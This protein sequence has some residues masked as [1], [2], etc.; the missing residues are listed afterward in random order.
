[1]RSRP[2]LKI[3]SDKTRPIRSPNFEDDSIKEIMDMERIASSSL[4]RLTD[5]PPDGI[6]GE[7][8][9]ILAE[10]VDSFRIDR[11]G[12][13]KL[14][15]NKGEVQV[16]NL[17]Q[18]QD[19]PKPMGPMV[20]QGIF[21]WSVERLINGDIVCFSD[22]DDL[23]PE[24]SRDRLDFRGAG[25]DSCLAIPLYSGGSVEFCIFA[26]NLKSGRIW[27]KEAI[28]L[29]RLIGEVL[30]NTIVH[31]RE[32]GLT[33]ARLRFDRFISDLSVRFINVAPAGLDLEIGEA[34]QQI[35]NYFHFDRCGLIALSP[36]KVEAR[37]IHARYGEGVAPVP[38]RVDISRMFPWAKEKI[39][40]G[41]IVLFRGRSGMPPEAAVDCK[42]WE[43]IGTITSIA[44]PIRIAGS[45]DFVLSAH[46]VRKER[47]RDMEMVS[48]LRILGEI[49][50]N[51][52]IRC[53]SE[54]ERQTSCNEIRM[55]KE[56]LELETEQL[57]SEIILCQRHERI[58]GQSEAMARTLLLAQQVA[59]TNSTVLICGETGTGKELIAQ[60][61]HEM[62]IRSKRAMVKVNC[63][64]L[65]AA[66]VE[67]ELFGREK[68]AYTGALTRQAGRF[69]AADGAT[70]F[71]DEIAELS[72]DLQA[73]LL[74]VLQEGEFE[75]LGSPKTIK[76][77]VRLITATNR[78]LSEE[79]LK[80]KFREDLYYRLNV[81][82]IPV[83]PLRERLE[84]IPLLVWAF[85]NEFGEKMGKK[86]TRVTKQDMASLQRYHWPGN[87]RELRNVIEY[88][89]IVSQG[90]TLLL[91]QPESNGHQKNGILT[92]AEA[93]TRQIRQALLQTGWRI[94][95][96]GGAAKLL[97]VNPSTLYSRMQKLGIS[98]RNDKDEMSN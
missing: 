28:S 3:I 22:P 44:L 91:R 81:F 30:V 18:R 96:E 27:P 59:P 46:D 6:D 42:S 2:S 10:V 85:I 38:E 87:V 78:N 89:V 54:E 36:D 66:L 65:P 52:M 92:L 47:A 94:K 71:L 31:C 29:F 7:I 64:S 50:A 98:N 97:G 51:A 83:P 26:H 68:G 45:V 82:Q 25:I 93:E 62:S 56:K 4:T 88:A 73:K 24:A 58:L 8:N 5:L 19:V 11:C 39:L 75:R 60:A 12:L 79:M 57:K 95:G 53:R 41:E 15:R 32:R 21:P 80:G 16:T 35:L 70:L 9:S 74:R 17:Y 86:I 61:I 48:R 67:S 55:L 72:F 77:D 90:E 20:F 14:P 69:E 84:D 34:L 76:V 40:A 37:V 63:A 49:I 23:P 1:M 43:E 13:M 33:D